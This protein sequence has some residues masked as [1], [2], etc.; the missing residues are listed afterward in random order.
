MINKK[1]Y[2]TSVLLVAVVSVLGEL[3]HRHIEPTNLVMLYLAIV[4]I[5]AAFLGRGPAVLVSVLSVASFDLLF[6]PPRFHPTV[7]DAQ[8]LITFAGLLVVG[9]IIS[10]LT[11]RAREHAIQ[12]EEREKNALA[13][14]RLSRE[15]SQTLN[16][17]AICEVV[18][19]HIHQTF[20][21]K[22]VIFI[23]CGDKLQS[24]D[25][26]SDLPNVPVECP[27]A[28]WSIA[29]HKAA[30]YGTAHFTE[31]DFVYFPLMSGGK[32]QGVLAINMIESDN[33]QKG[34][35]LMQMLETSANQAALAMERVLLAEETKSIE[36]MREKEKLQTAVFHSI[37]HDL[38]TPLV[39]I[40]GTLSHLA[41]EKSLQDT[42]NKEMV[43]TALGETTRL[44][45]VVTNLLDMTRVEAGSF[46]FANKFCDLKE[47]VGVALGNF[48]KEIDKRPFHIALPDDLPEVPID[49]PLFLKVIV[50]ILDNALKYS[51][52][53]TP[54][55]ISAHKKDEEIALSI[56][57]LGKGVKESDLD[58]IFNKFYRSSAM[59]EV[60]GIGLGLS[61]CR[62]IIEA[63]QG[64]IFARNRKEGGF[65]IVIQLP[66]IRSC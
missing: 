54:I 22:C 28:I 32:I 51:G 59:K 14:F 33:K 44:N 53:N 61:I 64:K 7:E 46:R 35:L 11:S 31:D 1:K 34:S 42:N 2:L 62:G 49:F 57:D 56:L 47:V 30:G 20:G 16:I 4:V 50:N 26:N 13:L 27:P 60:K 45:Q 9:L 21:R 15:L 43:D 6:V 23:L 37:S 65:Q 3:I 63:H 12:A 24:C 40:T 55:E 38:R 58:K 5:S 41:S 36:I 19:K 8:Y 66:L 39:A 52:T 25:K 48:E 29:N 17:K 10:D 18:E